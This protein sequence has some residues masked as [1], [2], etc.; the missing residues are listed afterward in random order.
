[1]RSRLSGETAQ[2]MS[3]LKRLL[4]ARGVTYAQLARR[5]GLSEP[6]VKRIFSSHSLTLARLQQICVAL[7]ASIQEVARLAGEPDVEAGESL[8]WD[9]EAALAQD[10]KLFACLYLLVNGRTARELRDLLDVD[11]RQLRKLFARLNA[12]G[13]VELRPNLGAR[14][15][16]AAALRWRPDGPIRRLYESQVRD[17]FMKSAFAGP[18]EALHFRSAELSEA[19]CQVLLRKLDRLSTEFRELA[20]LDRSLPSREKRSF[21]MMLAARPW[22]FSM[23]L[24]ISSRAGGDPSAMRR[25]TGTIPA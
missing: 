18:S 9:Q 3:S 4:K 11:E 17:E 20:E 19:S 24:G 10:P 21:A 22:V 12:L 16:K 6:S 7:D 15:R 14:V 2:I 8:T 23:F 1:M 25:K 5:I 13:L